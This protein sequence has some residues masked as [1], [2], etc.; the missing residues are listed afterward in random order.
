MN[1]KKYIYNVKQADFFINEGV[2][3]LGTGV[4]PTTKKIWWCFGYKECQEAY[5]KWNNREH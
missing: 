3:L 2:K 1:N 5:S 4:H